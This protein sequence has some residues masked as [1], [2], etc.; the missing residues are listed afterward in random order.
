MRN[1]FLETIYGFDKKSPPENVGFNYSFL[2]SVNNRKICLMRFLLAVSALIITFIDPTSP[3]RFIEITYFA[4]L[5]YCTYSAILYFLSLRDKSSV[6]TNTIIWTDTAWYLVLISLSSGTNSI[7]YLFFLFSILV[8]AF[9]A[10]FKSGLYVTFVSAL[11]FTV[12]GYITAPQGDE[13]ELNRFLIRP[14]YLIMF[15]YLISYWGGQEIKFK[16]HL[17]LFKDVNRLSNPRFGV[18]RTL[19][20]ILNRLRIFYDAESCVL[21]S[22]DSSAAAYEW[23]E[24]N[25]DNADENVKIEQTEAV[26]PL[27]KLPGELAIFYQNNS[28]VWYRK[29]EHRAYDVS[30]GDEVEIKPDIF[31]ALA[32]LLEAES[33]FSVPVIKRDEM[34]GR[35]YLTSLQNCFE[36]SEL[37][38]ISQLINQVLTAIENVEL[39]DQLASSAADR[40]R[41][42]I[43]R[44]IHDSTI[45]P[46]I[47]LKLGLEALEIKCA[48]GEPIQQDIEKLL[49]LTDSTIADLRGYVNI[50]KGEKGEVEGSALILAIKQQAAKFQEFHNIN[51]KVEASAGF[52]LD[53]RLAAEAFQIVSEGLSNIKRHAKAEKGVIRLYQEAGILFLEIENDHQ[54]PDVIVEFVPKSIAG[55]AESLGGA[56]RVERLD[57]RTK[58]LVEIPL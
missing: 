49:K 13:F 25:R 6:S 45:Q 27:I 40:Q 22:F 39:L 55:R 44:D 43:S 50:L 57:N 42:K 15:G 10:G 5:G 17:M 48:S 31:I 7:F 16:R 58:V 35:L 14:V 33:F 26:A 29:P 46:Y 51:I 18:N 32:D 3:D 41:Q 30:T 56:A 37:E 34:V 24:A 19:S 54:T 36:R 20:D 23:R 4:L 53:D 47:G 9:R 52:R 2:E 11:L 21:I 12:V 28:D 8:A 1:G 38:F